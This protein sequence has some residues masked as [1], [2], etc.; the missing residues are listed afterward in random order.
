MILLNY[1]FNSENKN[2]LYI[3]SSL[4]SI[5]NKIFIPISPD[6]VK[7]VTAGLLQTNG[8]LTLT[9]TYSIDDKILLNDE[10]YNYFSFQ[11]NYKNPLNQSNTINSTVNITNKDGILTITLSHS[12]DNDFLIFTIISSLKEF[13]P[14]LIL[15]QKLKEILGEGFSQFYEVRENNLSRLEN[16]SEK[17]ISQNETY[18]TQLDVEKDKKIIELEEK[19]SKKEN[20][21][22]Q[23]FLD[24]NQMLTQREND[25]EE[26]LKKLDDRSSKHAR[27]EIRQDLKNEI[28]SRNKSFNLT[29]TTISKRRSVHIL[30][31]LFICILVSFIV[32]TLYTLT[33]G[34]DKTLNILNSVKLIFSFVGLSAT[35]IYYIRWNDNWFKRHADEEFYMKRFLL[36][37]ERAS[38]VVEMALEWNEEKGSEIPSELL[39]KLTN[40]LFESSNSEKIKHPS[41]DIISRILGGSS[42]LDLNIPN[43]ANLKLNKKGIKE[44]RNNYN[45]SKED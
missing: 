19:F 18:R 13:F 23:E 22:T 28:E 25:L 43:V 39:E 31:V 20:T 38:W 7:H 42:Q 21:L 6:S 26:K 30:F 40:N 34:T 44:L 14:E 4:H 33:H 1:S 17:L 12:N 32:Y 29:K 45:D 35:I 5:I 3:I 27:R 37:I 9:K 41:E 15:H 8:S 2:N 16:L 11:T 10:N 24:K 36:D